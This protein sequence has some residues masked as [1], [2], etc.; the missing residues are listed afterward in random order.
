MREIDGDLYVYLGEAHLVIFKGDL[1]YRKLLGDMNW[2]PTDDFITC[3]RGFQPTNICTLR[4]LKSD[5]VCGLP[6]GKA[7][8]LGRLDPQWMCTGEYGTIKFMD[9]YACDCSLNK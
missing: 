7:E 8:E 2:D 4:T 9:R 6:Q 3:L 5:L 1:N